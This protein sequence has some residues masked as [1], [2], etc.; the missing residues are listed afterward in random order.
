MAPSIISMRR[1]KIFAIVAS[2]ALVLAAC[3]GDDNGSGP[4]DRPTDVPSGDEIPADVREMLDDAG[5]D[6]DDLEALSDMDPDDFDL[7]SM[8]DDMDEFVSSMGGGDGGGTVTV[9]D[10]TYTVD[11]DVCIAF[12]DDFSLDGPAVGSDG[13]TAWVD[14][15]YSITTREE[16]ADYMDDSQLDLLFRDGAD[17]FTDMSLSVSLG[18]T[19]RFDFVEDQPSWS[20]Y[21][22]DMIDFGLELDWEFTGN[23]LR[24]SGE[25]TDDNYVALDFGETVPIQF[26]VGCS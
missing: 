12:G 2:A 23:S 6:L 24:G 11:A 26:D 17:E 21:G 16:M 14:A 5:I 3:G 1:P 19:G 4:I 9:G 10:V 25:A 8:M 20:V 7:E 22:G 15:Y 18:Q 13:S